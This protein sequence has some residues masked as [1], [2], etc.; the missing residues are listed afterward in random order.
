MKCFVWEANYNYSSS[1]LNL[2]SNIEYEIGKDITEEE[3]KRI[4]N[5]F[6]KLAKII[7]K[8]NKNNKD[9]KNDV[10]DDIKNDIKKINI[11]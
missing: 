7:D 10:K 1:K 3:A 11:L 5:D 8:D 9:N 6:P 2:N 4:C